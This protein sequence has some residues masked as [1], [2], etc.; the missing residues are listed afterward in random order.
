MKIDLITSLVFTVFV[1]L[2]VLSCRLPHLI[3]WRS[4][5]VGTIFLLVDVRIGL[6][7]E[8]QR[9]ATSNDRA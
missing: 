3:I 9:H 4:L 6:W 5:S 7:G 1:V 8:A 2:T